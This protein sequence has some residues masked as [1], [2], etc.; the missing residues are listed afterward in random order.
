MIENKYECIPLILV[1]VMIENIYFGLVARWGG[2]GGG[3]RIL[4]SPYKNYGS[5]Y[6]LKN[7]G[8]IFLVFRY[9][10]AD[11]LGTPGITSNSIRLNY[12]AVKG[13]HDSELY[14]ITPE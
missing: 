8:E 6:S 10:S 2:G 3:T 5:T 4:L 11:S 1:V 7:S 12:V 9:F 14:S 13:P